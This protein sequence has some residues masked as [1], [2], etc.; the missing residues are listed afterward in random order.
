M[1]P[2]VC[3]TGRGPLNSAFERGVEALLA[4]LGHPEPHRPNKFVAAHPGDGQ[5]S[6]LGRLWCCRRLFGTQQLGDVGV[7]R[8]RPV[9]C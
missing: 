2:R 3:S 9:T 8:L 7:D 5:Q 6:L 1:N 4:R